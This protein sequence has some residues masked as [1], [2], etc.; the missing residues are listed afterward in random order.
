M[1]GNPK[2]DRVNPKIWEAFVASCK[3]ND[4]NVNLQAV[5]KLLDD[6]NS[7]TAQTNYGFDLQLVVDG[8]TP[9]NVAPLYH[10]GQ[11]WTQ[12]IK[13]ERTGPDVQAVLDKLPLSVRSG[14]D[15]DYEV[16]QIRLDDLNSWEHMMGTTTLL[17][18]FLNIRPEGGHCYLL[19]DDPLSVRNWDNLKE[20]HTVHFPQLPSGGKSV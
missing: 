6:L 11:Q 1:P 2:E 10:D 8:V 3:E 4:M 20:M 9:P 15:E 12:P 14:Q 18:F 7:K 5:Q 16:Y 17:M 13:A 19:P